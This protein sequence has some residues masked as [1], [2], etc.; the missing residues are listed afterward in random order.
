MVVL[1][2]NIDG[3]NFRELETHET[4]AKIAKHDAIKFVASFDNV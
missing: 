1:F 3:K 4:L 2:H